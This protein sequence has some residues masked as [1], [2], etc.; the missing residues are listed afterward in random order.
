MRQASPPELYWTAGFWVIIKD[1]S[2]HNLAAN[3][4]SRTMFSLF[5]DL[6]DAS[7]AACR[8]ISTMWRTFFLGLPQLLVSHVVIAVVLVTRMPRDRPFSSGGGLSRP[9]RLLLI[10]LAA[11]R[12]A[13]ILFADSI[14]LW[15]VVWRLL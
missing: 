8:M 7:A 6:E 3:L 5:C 12:G 10:S 2:R 15:E 11:V 9:L 13:R 4:S 1:L 14:P